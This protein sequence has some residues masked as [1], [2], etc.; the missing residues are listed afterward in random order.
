MRPL[1]VDMERE[2]TFRTKVTYPKS[3]LV[4]DYEERADGLPGCDSLLVVAR[5]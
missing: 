5:N 1:K 3:V 4:S 2:Y